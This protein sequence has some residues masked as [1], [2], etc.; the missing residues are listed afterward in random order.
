MM[1]APR[2]RWN[3]QPTAF[4]SSLARRSQRFD[5]RLLTTDAFCWGDE[6][7][8][9]RQRATSSH[10]RARLAQMFKQTP[11]NVLAFANVQPSP[12]GVN[13]VHPG[14]VRRF[15]LNGSVSKRVSV[16]VVVRHGSPFAPLPSPV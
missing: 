12:R 15:V 2:R 7:E 11:F 8:R 9:K 13:G 3:P 5:Q 1:A 10:T 16:I 6:F 14:H 4:K